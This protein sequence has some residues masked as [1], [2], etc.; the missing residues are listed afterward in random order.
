MV[1]LTAAGTRIVDQ[2][3]V[4]FQQVLMERMARLAPHQLHT[5]AELLEQVAPPRDGQPPAPMFF[6]EGAGED[7]LP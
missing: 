2:S 6:Q 1:A 3:P 4:P 5:L 7:G